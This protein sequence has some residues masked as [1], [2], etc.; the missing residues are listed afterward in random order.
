VSY[1]KAA[2]LTL[3]IAF[4]IADI[5]LTLKLLGVGELSLNIVSPSMPCRLYFIRYHAPTHIK[6]G[7]KILFYT[8]DLS[9]YYRAGMPFLK[10]VAGVPGDR[11]ERR[12][13]CFY[14]N[15]KK[16]GCALEFDLQGRRIPYL[17]DLSGIIPE[18]CYFVLGKHPRSFDSR[19]WGYV[20][21][22]QVA[23]IGYCIF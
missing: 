19:Y 17:A 21:H 9:P 22:D 6:R 13:R 4:S 2:S 3:A 20:K 10:V 16:A 8:P 15:G 12:G 1:R 5:F 18:G 23:G 11:I 7:T 14:I